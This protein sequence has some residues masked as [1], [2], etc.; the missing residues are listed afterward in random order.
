MTLILLRIVACVA[1]I[2]MPFVLLA[3]ASG[4]AEGALWLIFPVVLAVPALSLL[5]LVLVPVEAVAGAHGLSKNV[6]V[7][8]TGAAG[9]AVI[10]LGMLGLQAS[11]QGKPL[12]AALTAGLALKTTVIWMAVG[13]LLGC[14]WRVSEWIVRSLGW[15]GHG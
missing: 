9:G 15:A 10:W 13:A 1:M 3:L 14:F 2:V 5:A 8:G 4:R 7:I 12:T 6:T 11:A